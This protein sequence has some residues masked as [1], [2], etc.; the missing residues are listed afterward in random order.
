MN[1]RSSRREQ[2]ATALVR[3]INP[4]LLRDLDRA[5]ADANNAL[6]G[7][8]A[9][10]SRLDLGDD[11]RRVFHETRSTADYTAAFDAEAPLVT[12]IVATFNRSSALTQRCI[13]SLLAQ[14]HRNI[15]V[16]V[17]G[18]R[19]TDD[20]AAQVARITDSRLEYVD[21][22]DRAEYPS[23][24]RHRWMVAGGPAMN[25]GLRLAQ[26]SF[27]THLDDDDF[28]EP[29]RVEALV[30]ICQEERADIAWH[31]YW[32]E[33]R[34]SSWTL[35]ES[36]EFRPGMVTTSSLFYHSWLKRIE[37]D[38]TSYLNAEPGDANRVR[39]ISWLDPK[40]VRLDQPLLKHY[41]EMSTIFGTK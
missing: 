15:Q 11:L 29:N 9:L 12:C 10:R 22:V 4:G 19:C 34:N 2:Y 31:P 21:L 3:R 7:L 5:R 17:V 35:M 25:K 6:A 18:D 32:A 28:H 38:P 27:I 23:N 33:Q 39:K 24:P 41:R 36:L 8:D 37:W 20:T 16:I 14:S 26:G 30:R 13:P 40:A 1:P